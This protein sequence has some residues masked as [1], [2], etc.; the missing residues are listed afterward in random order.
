M[1]AERGALPIGAAPAEVAERWMR[2]FAADTDALIAAVQ[3]HPGDLHRRWAAVTAR[4]G[5]WP[6]RA[7][8]LLQVAR[9]LGRPLPPSEYALPEDALEALVARA[10][11]SRGARVPVRGAA[12]HKGRVGD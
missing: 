2:Q 3:H 8:A 10:A 11:R 6:G 7:E 4:G 12:R 5:R 9:A 1:L